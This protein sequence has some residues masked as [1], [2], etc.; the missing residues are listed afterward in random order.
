MKIY[1][2]ALLQQKYLD[3]QTSDQNSRATPVVSTGL[4]A[5]FAASLPPHVTSRDGL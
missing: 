5:A 1:D 2:H 4:R 3:M